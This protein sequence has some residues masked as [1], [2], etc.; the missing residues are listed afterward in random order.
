M[1]FHG[2]PIFILLLDAI[3]AAAG[4]GSAFLEGCGCYGFARA[5]VALAVPVPSCFLFHTST[6]VGALDA[7]QRQLLLCSLPLASPSFMLC[8]LFIFPVNA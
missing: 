1:T 2:L 4:S 3:E 6:A 8:L 5:R 7:L